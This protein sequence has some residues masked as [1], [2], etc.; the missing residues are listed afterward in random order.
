MKSLCYYDHKNAYRVLDEYKFGNIPFIRHILTVK[1]LTSMEKNELKTG[2]EI[3]ENIKNSSDDRLITIYEFK[4]PTEQE[5]GY[6]DM[7]MHI[8]LTNTYIEEEMLI[9]P[10]VVCY[11]KESIA[12]IFEDN[13]EIIDVLDNLRL[14]KQKIEDLPRITLIKRNNPETGLTYIS[15][16]SEI[17]WLLKKIREDNNLINNEVNVNIRNAYNGEIKY[18][19]E[20]I[21]SVSLEKESAEDAFIESN[22]EYYGINRDIIDN[23]S[24]LIEDIN[25]N[26]DSLYK[27]GMVYPNLNEVDI[28]FSVKDRIWKLININKIGMLKYEQGKYIDEWESIPY[29]FSMIYKVSSELDVKEYN[30]KELESFQSKIQNIL[31]EENII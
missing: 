27:L 25:H 28:V 10:A 19:K 1:N 29:A 7:E 14:N 16:N 6:V 2:M 23:I 13:L 21:L 17:L 5:D 30:K 18:I 8:T 12:N 15:L 3:L 31:H 24:A 22:F 9:D 11:N 4:K 26:L 20:N